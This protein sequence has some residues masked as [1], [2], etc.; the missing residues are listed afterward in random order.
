MCKKT[1]KNIKDIFVKFLKENNIYEL[2]LKYMKELGEEESFEKYLRKTPAP[3]YLDSC[4]T[5]I[6]TKEGSI[7]WCDLNKKWQETAYR[8]AEEIEEESDEQ[9]SEEKSEPKKDT[10]LNEKFNEFLKGAGVYRRFFLYL[11]EARSKESVERYFDIEPYKWV[12]CAFPWGNTDEGNDFWRTLSEDW[13]T[14][15]EKEQKKQ[16]EQKVYKLVITL[17]SKDQNALIRDRDFIKEWNTSDV[18]IHF[19]DIT[20]DE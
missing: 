17:K 18:D 7:F 4:F 19:S 11:S 14:V 3:C 15:L 8:N 12:S 16:K 9:K 10:S 20:K 2:F 13:K 5:F 1:N 6:E